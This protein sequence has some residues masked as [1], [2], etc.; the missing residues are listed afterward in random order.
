[1]TQ[2]LTRY[3]ALFE[4]MR[5]RRRRAEVPRGL[6]RVA[7]RVALWWEDRRVRLAWLRR[8]KAKVQNG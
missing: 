5:S 3:T 2:A 1:M 6:D 4:S 7:A 8:R